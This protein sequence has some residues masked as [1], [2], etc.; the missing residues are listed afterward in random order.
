MRKRSKLFGFL[1][2][3]LAAPVLAQSACG[4]DDTGGTA[5]AGNVV[6]GGSGGSGGAATGGS[7]GSGAS[8]GGGQ[9]QNRWDEG[10]WDQNLWGP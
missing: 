7:A 5:G 10:I 1:L 6:V 3:M 8:T 4:G 2:V 9:A